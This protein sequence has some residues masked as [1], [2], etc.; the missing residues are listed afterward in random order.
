MAKAAFNRLMP[1]EFW[2]EVVDR[3]AAEAPDTLLLAEAF[4]LLEGYFVRTLGMH[5]VYNSAFM[6]MVRDENN[7]GYRRVIRETLEFDPAILGRYVNFLTNPDEETALEQFGTGDKYFGAVTLLATL[8]GLPMIG[9]GQLE[10][11][12]EKYGME[13]QRARLDERPDEAL[14]AHFDAQI[15]PLLHDRRR[16]GGSADF[17]LYDVVG[18]GG[19]VEDVFAYSNGRGGDRSLIAYHNR[20]GST[21]GWIRDSV[22][23]AEKRGDGSRTI[24]RDTLAAALGLAGPDDGWLRIRDRRGSRETLRS[25]GELRSSG[26]FVR[27]DAY[28]CLVLDDLRE[29]TSTADEP[30]S[31]LAAGLGDR[32]VESLE[33][34]LADLRLRPLHEAVAAVVVP[35]DPAG[36]ALAMASVIERLDR[37]RFDELRLANVLARA[38]FD[39]AALRRI[40][41]AIGLE[42]PRTTPDPVLLAAIW[43]RDPEVSAFLEVHEWEGRTFLN[44]DRWTDLVEAANALDRAAGARRA[45]PAIGKLRWAASAAGFDVERLPDAL[46]AGT[47]PGRA[48]SKA[49]RGGRRR[50]V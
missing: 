49:G 7:A 26:F 22:P 44:G 41:L 34:A 46:A 48:S 25:V 23:F 19:L 17:R 21:S 35:G 13:F 29:V 11:F 27:L 47:P 43:L 28:E 38:G 24:R 15:V 18:D 45:S 40:R 16:Y 12:T 9:H 8:P 10:G 2:R 36:T 5:R 6:H 37:T 20:F 3:V 39:E 42:H 4:W 50:T 1:K 32:W 33:D 31:A 14:Q 30:W